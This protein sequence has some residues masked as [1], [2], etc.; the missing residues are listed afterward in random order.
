[1][2]EG[3]VVISTFG[4]N[5]TRFA[6]NHGPTGLFDS[7]EQDFQQFIVTIGQKL[8]GE[9]PNERTGERPLQPAQSIRQLTKNCR[10]SQGC[11]Q[12]GRHGA[13]RGR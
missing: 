1:M 13:G 12:A 2:V 10:R 9:N 7:Y 11:P 5:V 8:G 6:M 4:R 3:E